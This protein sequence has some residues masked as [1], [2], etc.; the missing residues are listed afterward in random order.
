[1]AQQAHSAMFDARE[2]VTCDIEIDWETKRKANRRRN[3]SSG[4]I[5][6]FYNAVNKDN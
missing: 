1:V 6:V 2:V 4:V 3:I 5:S